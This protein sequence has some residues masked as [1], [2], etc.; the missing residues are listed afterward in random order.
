MSK[1]RA[2]QKTA[3]IF[4]V[5][6]MTSGSLLAGCAQDDRPISEIPFFQSAHSAGDAQSG[7][8]RSAD[9]VM[10]GHYEVSPE[11]KLLRPKSIYE[12]TP[13]ELPEV[14]KVYDQNGAEA[15]A[16]YFVDV[17][18]YTWLSGDSSVLRSISAESCTWCTYIA[19][20]TDKR[21]QAGGWVE[22][23][24]NRVLDIE[25]A[26]EAPL[27]PGLWDTVLHLEANKHNIY[28]GTELKSYSDQLA[29]FR[30]QMRQFDGM[31][32]ITG[33]KGEEE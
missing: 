27:H 26:Y 9:K 12:I 13:P 4:A 14:A 3:A 32:K 15:F 18:D 21:T 16:E 23:V 7:M 22:H 19:D 31:W 25:P 28:N 20:E 8:T 6:I 1:F 17:L 11:G 33:A 24:N 5:V 29:R 30:V 10:S 2:S